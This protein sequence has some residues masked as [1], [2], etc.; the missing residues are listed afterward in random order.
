MDEFQKKLYTD[1]RS[2]T[3]GEREV[4]VATEYSAVKILLL[5]RNCPALSAAV[6]AQGGQVLRCTSPQEI[7]LLSQFTGV[8]AIL[9]FPVAALDSDYE[10]SQD[11]DPHEDPSFQ[12]ATASEHSVT[13]VQAVALDVVLAQELQRHGPQ[14]SCELSEEAQDEIGALE[15]IY[16]CNT[17]EGIQFARA[18]DSAHCFLA[19]QGVVACCSLSPSYPEK[20][21]MQL[22]LLGG[23]TSDALRGKLTELRLMCSE[24]GE[25][26]GAPQ[27]FNVAL[28]L[29]Q[30][31]SSTD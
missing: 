26:Y 13:T 21:G 20:A 6:E 12:T 14:P 15:A 23:Q 9:R 7:S 8:C 24:G 25:W 31:L 27:L 19:V 5:S 30:A 10:S 18:G 17:T 29:Q 1:E 11:E 3:Y 16:P 28:H 22:E 4:A 2:V